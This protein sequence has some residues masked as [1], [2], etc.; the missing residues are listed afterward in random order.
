MD[1]GSLLSWLLG[2]LDIFNDDQNENITNIGQDKK[3]RLVT[4]FPPFCFLFN[5]RFSCVST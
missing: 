2:E 4:H 5:L 3:S 1:T